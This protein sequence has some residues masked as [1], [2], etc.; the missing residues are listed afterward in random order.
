MRAHRLWQPISRRNLIKGTGA[1]ALATAL[2]PASRIAAK[3]STP[4]VD[5]SGTTLNILQWSH[6]VPR[7]DAWFDQ[8]VQDWATANGVTAKVDHIN[9]ADVP[10]AIAAEIS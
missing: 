1:A 8:F 3:Q 4:T 6:F 5:I 10:A 7:Y 2:G 9:T